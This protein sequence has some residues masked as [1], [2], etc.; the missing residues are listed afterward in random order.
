M[1]AVQSPVFFAVRCPIDESKEQRSAVRAAGFERASLERRASY[2]S[3]GGSWQHKSWSR[4]AGNGTGS[5]PTMASIDGSKG[6]RIYPGIV[7]M[8]SI[9]GGIH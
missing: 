1:Q 8:N 9:Y 5:S 7:K 2:A 4:R 6:C 3:F